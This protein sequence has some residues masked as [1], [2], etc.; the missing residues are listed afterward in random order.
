MKHKGILF[1]IFLYLFLA[2]SLGSCKGEESFDLRYHFNTGDYFQ[3]RLSTEQRISQEIMGQKQDLTQKMRIEYDF[4]VENIDKNGFSFI[5]VTYKTVYFQQD[6][7][8]GIIEYDSKN[9]PDETNPLILGFT[10]LPGESFT[11]KVSP[12]GMVKEIKGIENLI[13]RMVGKLKL[14]DSTKKD[15]L[16]R[17]FKEQFGEEAMTQTMENITA[18]Y[19]E[20]PVKVGESWKKKTIISKGFPMIINNTWTL[21]EV[22]NGKAIIDINSHIYTNKDAPPIDLRI[23]K[24]KYELSG[25]ES[26]QI[27]LGMAKQLNINCT[28]TQKLS[29]KVIVL[30]IPQLPEGMSWPITIEGIVQYESF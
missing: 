9:P 17:A 26:G 20:Q 25:I 30:D 21:R 4:S 16:K 8:I 18:I 10:C 12:E 2:I 29:G 15:D 1:K 27:K 24:I 13:E 22:N 3:L 5:K 23:M 7:P 14:V 6:G 11:M 19:P 28:T